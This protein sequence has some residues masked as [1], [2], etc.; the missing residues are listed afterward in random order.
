M[1]RRGNKSQDGLLASKLSGGKKDFDWSQLNPLNSKW[2]GGDRGSTPSQTWQNI[3]DA[4]GSD[5]DDSLVRHYAQA[6]GDAEGLEGMAYGGKGPTYPDEKL[7]VENNPLNPHEVPEFISSQMA[8]QKSYSDPEFGGMELEEKRIAAEKALAQQTPSL[9]PPEAGMLASLLGQDKDSGLA[10]A[11]GGM[12]EVGD[13]PNTLQ[14]RFPSLDLAG[15]SERVKAEEEGRGL[16]KSYGRGHDG[17]KK[18]MHGMLGY[19][20]K[21]KKPWESL[22]VLEG[23]SAAEQVTGSPHDGTAP[24]PSL[25]AAQTGTGDHVGVDPEEGEG[26]MAK[27]G[28]LMS[29]DSPKTKPLS[30]SKQAGIKIAT[31]LLTGGNRDAPVLAPSS[32]V[33]MGR[34]SFPG[35]LA[36]SKRPV[37][38]RYTPKGLG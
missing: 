9:A 38:Q 20:S 12:A 5:E 18:N 32:G 31:D 34:A 33:K 19:G 23:G 7:T 35:L 17:G 30:K 4:W 15:I 13:D 24:T 10:L 11:G 14:N 8:D 22:T 26:L 3:K 1:I 16:A 28:N 29:S 36:A 6:G 25:L 21:E 27:L 2:L 37:T